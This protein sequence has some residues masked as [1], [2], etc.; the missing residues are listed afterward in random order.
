LLLKHGYSV[1]GALAP[2]S[3]AHIAGAGPNLAEIEDQLTLRPV[4]LTNR[5]EVDSLIQDAQPDEIYHLAAPSVV[6]ASWID[7]IS[8]LDF[9][10]GSVVRL[11]DGIMRLTP[12]T[13]FFHAGSSEIFRA[14]GNAPQDE[15]APPR[16]T[17]PYGVGKLAGH[18][19]VNS[20]REQHGL[21]ATSGIL[22]NHESP[23]RP[24][25][26]VTRKIVNAAVAIKLGHSDELVL[27]DTSAQRDWG[28]AP[29]YVEAIWLMLQQDTPRD[30]VIA[31]GKLHTVQDLVDTSFSLLGL[32][33]ADHVRRDPALMRK[34]DEAILQGNPASAKEHLGWEP[35]TQFSDMLQ[36]MIDHELA[37][38]SA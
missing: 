3:E 7:P 33:V 26:F 31:T 19:L 15:D 21:Y 11:L 36:Q 30:F 22:Y 14:T 8:T 28:F 32:E 38:V 6:P 16:P 35:R 13:R 20:Y 37:T 27:G 10:S 9:M 24:V 5:D 29:D 4:D 18:A 2:Y 12:E 25:D 1:T 34:G 23:R 17:S